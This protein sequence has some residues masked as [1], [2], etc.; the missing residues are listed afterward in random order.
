MLTCKQIYSLVSTWDCRHRNIITMSHNP[1]RLRVPNECLTWTLNL[2]C[3]ISCLPKATPK[4]DFTHSW[5][6]FVVMPVPDNT[7]TSPQCSYGGLYLWNASQR[8]D[9]LLWTTNH[10]R[11]RLSDS[12]SRNITCSAHDRLLIRCTRPQTIYTWVWLTLKLEQYTGWHDLWRASI[13][14][15][16][17]RRQQGTRR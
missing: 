9:S 13:I 4:T 17:L 8:F 5:V 11:S 6:C 3:I 16:S 14:L 10:Q 12:L 2:Q 7:V 1:Q 15:V